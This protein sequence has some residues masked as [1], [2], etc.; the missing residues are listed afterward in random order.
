MKPSKRAQGIRGA[1]LAGRL[2]AA[3]LLIVLMLVATLA[4]PRNVD[5]ADP[6]VCAVTDV[7]AVGPSTVIFADGFELGDISLWLDSTPAF[8]ATEILDIAFDVGFD[9]DLTGD[10]I[11]DLKIS[12]PNGHLYQVL[13]AL[14]SSQATKQGTSVRVEGYPH[15]L[16]VQVLKSRSATA[17]AVAGVVLSMPVGG[18]LIVTNSLY[19]IWEVKTF[20]DGSS[21]ACSGP[22]RFNLIQ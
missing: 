8:S 21:A 13:T 6:A 16:Q 9:G 12:T 3:S 1:G 18:S 10:H 11:L 4:V 14:V 15:P 7:V 19:G 2:S 5:A 22:T 20:L 17:K